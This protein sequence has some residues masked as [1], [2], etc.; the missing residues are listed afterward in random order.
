MAEASV[1]KMVA[2]TTLFV[3]AMNSA[4]L[5]AEPVAY[6]IGLEER[7]TD[8]ARQVDSGGDGDLESR[9]NFGINYNSDPGKC[10][11]SVSANLGYGRWLDDT[12]DPETYVNSD[13][14]GDCQLAGSF[15]WDISNQTR[16]IIQDSR[17]GNNPDNTSRKNIFSTGPRY[18][19][20]LSPQDQLS[21][22]FRYES[23]NYD[24][25]DETDSDRYVGTASWNHLLSSTLSGGLS[26]QLDN[27]EMD[28]GQEI[29]RQTANLNFNK[30]W[31]STQVS[32]SVGVS[33]IESSFAGSS[34][35]N[36]GLVWSLFLERDLNS[37]SSIY[38]NGNHQLTDQTSDFDIVFADL[39][40]NVEQTEAIEV[41]AINAGYRNNL[42]N[43]DRLQFGI[44]YSMT[45]YLSSGYEEESAKFEAS[46]QRQLTSRLSGDVS[47]SIGQ[48]SYTD[49]DTEDE[50]VSMS[51]G[52]EYDMS[53][54]LSGRLLVSREEKIS[55]AGSR[56]YVENW[57][58]FGLN[59]R[60]Q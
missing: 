27:S 49:D 23:T 52:L 38:L 25:P 13:I 29:D 6:S 12:Y 40:F 26:V 58:E 11:G 45:E 8:N 33:K 18:E 43:G 35:D 41:T 51:A 5:S 55:D 15:Y 16:D 28:T 7:Y 48:N 34:S 19:M 3:S 30:R 37:S 36:D 9:I 53:R 56:E 21:L 10:N 14:F 50:T 39:V 32:G 4:P 31:V 42:T 2:L 47:G 22:E 60:F 44:S 20:R 24:E 17:G 46:Y 1:K 59:Y 54:A 57:V